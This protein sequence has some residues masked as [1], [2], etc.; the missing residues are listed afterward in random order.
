MP[1]SLK[2]T[3]KVGTMIIPILQMDT[4]AQG[5]EGGLPKATS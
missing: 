1:L 2:V 3:H 4:K 5:G